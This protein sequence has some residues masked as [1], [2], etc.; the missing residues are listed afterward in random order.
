MERMLTEHEARK[1]AVDAAT[2]ALARFKAT[3]PAPVSLS[4]SDTAA[5]L[6]LSVRT[7]A[8]MKP[9]KIGGKIPY[10]WVLKRLEV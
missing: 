4:V 9:E 6:G 10:S 1:L 2:E 5:M 8:R 3:H 7:I